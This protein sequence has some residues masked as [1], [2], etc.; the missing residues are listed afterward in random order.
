MTIVTIW[1]QIL[2]L[3]HPVHHVQHTCYLLALHT[4]DRQA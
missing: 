4:M 2:N 3:P 1:T